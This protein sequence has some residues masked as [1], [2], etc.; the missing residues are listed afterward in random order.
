MATRYVEEDAVSAALGISIIVPMWYT[1]LVFFSAMTCSAVST[2]TFFT[3][4]S[5]LM[6]PTTAVREM[7]VSKTVEERKV[8]LDKL[9]PMQRSDFL[10]I[11]KAMKGRPVSRR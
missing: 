5:S 1:S 4:L 8:A 2:T 10:G 11:Y 9:L 6:S 7:I 3:Y